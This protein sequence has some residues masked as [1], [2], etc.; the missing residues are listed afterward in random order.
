MIFSVLPELL[1]ASHRALSSLVCVPSHAPIQLGAHKKSSKASSIEKSQ[2][3]L[4]YG[5]KL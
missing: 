2:H 5:D 4:Q 1:Q 3:N